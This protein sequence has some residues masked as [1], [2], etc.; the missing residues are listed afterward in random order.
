M[1]KLFFPF[2]VALTIS[3]MFFSCEK[4]ETRVEYINNYDTLY[5][6]DTLYVRDTIFNF[7]TLFIYDSIFFTDTIVIVDTVIIQD[8]SEFSYLFKHYELSSYD[9]VFYT[10]DIQK[11]S[12]QICKMNSNSHDID[13][14][15]EGVKAYPIWAEDDDYIY[16]VDLESYCIKMKNVSDTSITDSIVVAIDRNVMFLWHDIPLELFLFSYKVGSDYRLAAINYKTGEIIELTSEGDSETNPVSSKVD[17]WI[18]YSSFQ[19]GTWDIYRR[20]LDGSIKEVVY[21]DSNYNLLAF[22]VSVDGKFLITPKAIDGK[23]YI[24]FYDIER[25]SIIHELELPIDGHPMYV[26][27]SDDNRAIFFVNGIFDNYSE[28]RNIYRMALDRTQFFQLTNFEAKLAMR[29]LIR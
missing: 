28:P 26:S 15:E 3:S 16:Y 5:I 22:N 1:K 25:Q 2:L 9:L 6:T 10:T 4:E 20:N 24:V 17:D 18:Y 13:V 11:T 12:F 14:L 21:E 7:D 23:G 29:P 8:T 19:E 27:I